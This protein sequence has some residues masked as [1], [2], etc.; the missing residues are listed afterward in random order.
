M[1]DNRYLF[2]KSIG[3]KLPENRYA[4]LRARDNV[5]V[6]NAAPVPKKGRYHLTV[7]ARHSDG[8]LASAGADVEIP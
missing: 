3:M 7:V 5:E 2:S 8:R 1:V 4:E 6:A